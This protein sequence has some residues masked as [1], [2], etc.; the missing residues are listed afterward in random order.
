MAE[1]DLNY[2]DFANSLKDQA[3]ELFQNGDTE[4]AI[5]LFSQAIDVDPDN[6]VFYS[7]RSAAYM[8]VDSVSKALRDA[9]KCVELAPQW[10]KGY[11]RLGVAQQCLRRFD[12]ALTTLKKGE[13]LITF[14]YAWSINYRFLA[15]LYRNRVGS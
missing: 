7:N 2:K 4:G 15:V 5:K 11:N 6:H 13:C 3:N 12:A 8:K 14:V 9:E 1:E 10:A